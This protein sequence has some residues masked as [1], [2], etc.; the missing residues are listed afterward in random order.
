M[1][2]GK[3]AFLLDGREASAGSLGLERVHGKS[4]EI[5]YSVLSLKSSQSRLGTEGAVECS[6]PDQAPCDP[7]PPAGWGRSRLS[8]PL[9][10]L[11]SFSHDPTKHLLGRWQLPGVS[12]GGQLVAVSARSRRVPGP[13]S[14][15]ASL[16]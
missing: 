5:V 8:P 10:G 6:W 12:D 7:G 16:S 1:F 2:L 11:Q 15:V 4:V 3:A 14:L 13:P 9:P